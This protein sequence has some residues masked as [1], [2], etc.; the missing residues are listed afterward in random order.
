MHFNT[1]YY[2]NKCL[3]S[4]FWAFGS[5]LFSSFTSGNC[6]DSRGKK[7]AKLFLYQMNEKC[8]KLNFL[9]CLPDM[10]EQKN[11]R[12]SLFRTISF[13]LKTEKAYLM[14]WL[15]LTTQKK[16]KKERFLREKLKSSRFVL[17]GV[18]RT[19]EIWYIRWEE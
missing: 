6:C 4:A 9:C 13:I 16:E 7:Q 10:H 11:C 5:S 15:I 2:K 18:E 14:L 19:G 3:L 12:V 1:F 8:L 17:K